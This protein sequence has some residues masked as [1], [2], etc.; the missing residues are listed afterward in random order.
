[1]AD[2]SITS[3]KADEDFGY[4]AN[5]ASSDMLAEPEMTSA[6]NGTKIEVKNLFYNYETRRNS[7]NANDERK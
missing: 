6:K 1:M 4:Q 2:L 7:L 3:K 5:F